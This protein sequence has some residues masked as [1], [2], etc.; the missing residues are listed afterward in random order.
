MEK[1]EK[2]RQGSNPSKIKFSECKF[3][4]PSSYTLQGA[5]VRIT[6]DQAAEFE[7]VL[8]EEAF[9]ID[10]TA[11]LKYSSQKTK[12]KQTTKTAGVE[13]AKAPKVVSNVAMTTG[14]DEMS[15]VEIMRNAWQVWHS[16]DKMSQTI[17]Y[18]SLRPEF[19][20]R[21]SF[22]EKMRPSL[23]FSPSTRRSPPS[24]VTVRLWS[25]WSLESLTDN[26][27]GG[28]FGRLWSNAFGEKSQRGG[29]K[30]DPRAFANVAHCV[31]ITLPLDFTGSARETV[32]REDILEELA[33]GR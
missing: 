17:R 20:R 30:A 7:D 2:A 1:D 15:G 4:G 5:S 13:L 29:R 24:T 33:M 32:T 18:S 8:P 31:E 3:E 21:V 27:K 26:T 10:P 22:P 25:F 23:K 28:F 14:L 19:S 11:Q 12:K 9:E 16:A 6:L